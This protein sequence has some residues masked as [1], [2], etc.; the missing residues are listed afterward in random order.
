[1]LLSREER[2]ELGRSQR[3]SAPLDAFATWT[4]RP[5][6][7]DPVALLTSGTDDLLTDL[8]P[9]RWSRMS[10]SVFAF[11]RGS[12]SLMADD[13]AAS[14]PTAD[15]RSCLTVQLCGDAH[16]GNFGGFA[17]AERGHVF[18][19]NDFDETLPGP[20]QWDVYRLAAS[21]VLAGLDVGVD[22]ERSSKSARRAVRSYRKWMSRYAEMT[23][24]ERWYSRIDATEAVESISSASKAN[25]ERALTRARARTSARLLPR[26][27]SLTEEGR[28]IN[29]APPLIIPLRDE[30]L[31]SG[32][33]DLATTYASTISD[34]LRYLMSGYEVC[35]IALKVVGVGSVGTRCLIVLL[36]GASDDDVLFL[37][38]KEAGDS[39]L[40]PHLPPSRY[41]HNGQR[42]VCG[43]RLVQ[44]AGDPFLGWASAVGREFYVRQLHDM[45]GSIDLTRLTP[46][47]LDEYGALCGWALSRAHARSGDPVVIAGYLDDG[48]TFDRA[49]A[50]GAARYAAVAAM[51]HERLMDAIAGGELAVASEGY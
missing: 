40:R 10:Q 23:R 33:M 48:S 39:A 16:I 32:V 15:H 41:P 51:D 14:D 3:E 17:T 2:R 22:L 37:Q 8:L 43:Q 27:S 18:D 47:S 6:R 21:V 28:R 42:V 35:D 12:A 31:R 45:K 4:P 19:V 13:L 29:P 49:V 26:L 1:M 20:F 36:T 5:G 38:V 7:P 50:A 24:L 25:R 46:D 11:F 34:E 30:S 44:A 9:I